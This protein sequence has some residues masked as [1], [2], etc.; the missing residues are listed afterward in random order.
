MA[1]N[2]KINLNQMLYNIDMANLKWYDTLDSE[3]KKS[4]SPYTAMRFVSNVQGQKAFKEHY[5]LSINDFAN[6]H[7]S[8]TQ[9]HEGDSTLFWKLLSLAGVKKKMFHP[10]VKAPKGKGKKSV[11]DKLLS[12]CYPNAKRDEIEL[13]KL[14]NDID[15]LK[16]QARQLGWTDKEIKEI[17]KK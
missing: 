14:V 16:K 5:I 8:I 3:E 12:E 2:K 6:K 17:G 9:K 11:I 13:L 7:F 10:W 1:T 4:F 15:I